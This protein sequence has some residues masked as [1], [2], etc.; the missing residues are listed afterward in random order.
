MAKPENKKPERKPPGIRP[1]PGVPQVKVT[2]GDKPA[3]LPKK[4]K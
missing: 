1:A 4:D 2:Q 3:A